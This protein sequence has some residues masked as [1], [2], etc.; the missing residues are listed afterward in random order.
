MNLLVELKYLEICVEVSDQGIQ[1]G[2][3]WKDAILVHDPLQGL[4]LL[5]PLS[6][7]TR[8]RVC[9]RI[10]PNCSLNFG[11]GETLLPLDVFTHYPQ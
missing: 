9:W 11:P 4:S 7:P 3:V 10:C 2:V 5:Q 1:I 8:M 6:G